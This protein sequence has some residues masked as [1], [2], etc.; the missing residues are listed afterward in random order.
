[1]GRV[2]GLPRGK[3]RGILVAD[4]LSAFSLIL[5]ELRSSRTMKLKADDLNPRAKY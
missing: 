4:Q 3:F 2:F 1:V 5:F